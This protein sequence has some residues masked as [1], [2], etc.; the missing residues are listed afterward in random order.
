MYK[1][2]EISFSKYH[3]YI[4]YFILQQMIKLYKKKIECMMKNHISLYIKI[5]ETRNFQ[6]K[7]FLYKMNLNYLNFL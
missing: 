6:K 1:N 4:Y 7:I 2:I 3:V 5:K